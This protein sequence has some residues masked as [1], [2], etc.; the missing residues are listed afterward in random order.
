M[1]IT[2]TVKCF[3]NKYQKKHQIINP[4]GDTTCPVI[5]S[6]EYFNF[7]SQCKV[8]KNLAHTN[9]KIIL[10]TIKIMYTRVL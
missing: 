10:L 3:Y 6:C 2:I 7:F 1:Y 8:F 5:F 9:L 4:I